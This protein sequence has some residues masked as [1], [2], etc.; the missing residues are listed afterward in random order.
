MAKKHRTLSESN[1]YEDDSIFRRCTYQQRLR[2]KTDLISDKP[3]HIFQKRISHARTH[4][5]STLPARVTGITNPSTFV[6]SNTSDAKKSRNGKV[7]RFFSHLTVSIKPL[8]RE[9]KLFSRQGGALNR[10][11]MWQSDISS[12][13]KMA[14]GKCICAQPNKKV[15]DSSGHCRRELL[16]LFPTF[17]V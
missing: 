8:Y 13:S 6:D 14:S 11:R 17:A 7:S 15:S 16:T 10:E 4:K 3:T 5:S 9:M 2:K 1:F 12:A